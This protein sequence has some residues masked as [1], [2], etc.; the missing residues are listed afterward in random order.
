MKVKITEYTGVIVIETLKPEADK[1]FVPVGPGKVG[2][3]LTNTRKHLGISKKALVLMKK[4][5][6]SS[7]DIGEVDAWKAGDRDCFGWL[8]PLNRIVGLDAELSNTGWGNIAYI[9]I[10]NET[11]EWVMKE[12]DEANK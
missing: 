5:P 9:D 8:G 11:S 2:S 7:D 1:D 3:V 12:I 10:P 4:L 6:V